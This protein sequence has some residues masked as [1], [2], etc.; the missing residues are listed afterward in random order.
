MASW[1]TLAL[2]Q[3][4][5]LENAEGPCVLAPVHRCGANAM[6]LRRPTTLRLLFTSPV[7]T[8]RTLG[9]EGATA[10]T[11]RS[12]QPDCV[13]DADSA[14]RYRVQSCRPFRHGPIPLAAPRTSV[15][16]RSLARRASSLPGS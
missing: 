2:L 6:S 12:S 3:P 8:Y 1:F 16:Q 15:N 13:L 4:D 10:R 9:L 5:D 11:L 14:R 7:P